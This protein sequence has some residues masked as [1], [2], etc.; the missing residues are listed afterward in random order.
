MF[1][2][3]YQFSLQRVINF[4]LIINARA[5]SIELSI[6]QLCCAAEKRERNLHYREG[7]QPRSWIFFSAYFPFHSFPIKTLN[8][9]LHRT[10]CTGALDSGMG[11]RKR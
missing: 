2:D 9:S 10:V 4:A 11:S 3:Y 1:N 5:S 7:T 6:R 8:R